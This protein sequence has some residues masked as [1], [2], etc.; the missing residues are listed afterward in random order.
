MYKD[1]DWSTPP[2]ATIDKQ[3]L[4][5][6]FIHDRPELK[7]PYLGADAVQRF[8]ERCD[9]EICNDFPIVF[10]HNDL[11]PPNIL[12]SPGPNLKVTAIIDWGQSGWYPSYWE[13]CKGRRVHFDSDDF[14]TAMQEEWHTKYLP[15]VL[16]PMDDEIPRVYLFPVSEALIPKSFTRGLLLGTELG[17]AR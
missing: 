9:I 12:L 8:H 10:I 5:D 17:I 4:N 11:C 13:Y 16:D 14:D 6:I 1:T 3:K 2:P 15:M 7:G